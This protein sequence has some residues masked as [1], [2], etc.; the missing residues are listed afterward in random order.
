MTKSRPTG[1]FQTRSTLNFT[2][3]R[4]L[5]I[6]IA[7]TY[8]TSTIFPANTASALSFCLATS[9]SLSPQLHARAPGTATIATNSI[10]RNAS[11][12]RVFMRH[13]V[14]CPEV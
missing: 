7:S 9:G 5:W 1:P 10:E 11:P 4:G 8:W 13:L 3:T 12:V 2:I 6:S 14:A